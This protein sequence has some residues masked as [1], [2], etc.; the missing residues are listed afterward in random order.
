MLRARLRQREPARSV[1]LRDRA[2]AR[3]LA[4]RGALRAS[5]HVAHGRRRQSGEA[6]PGRAAGRAL[7]G[8]RA[9]AGGRRGCA[10]SVRARRHL[11]RRD[12]TR[13]ALPDHRGRGQQS[14]GRGA[15]R[16]SA[17]RAGHPLGPGL[18]GQCGRPDQYRRGDRGLPAAPARDCACARSPTPCASCSRLRERAARRRWPR[19]WSSPAGASTRRARAERSGSRARSCPRGSAPGWAPATALRPAGALRPRA[20]RGARPG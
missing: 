14:A 9:G 7:A 16:G 8:S 4:G 6:D 15:N 20:F 13:A 2:R 19:R 5:R 3:G 18:R 17:C 12:R 11:R 1:G 10:R